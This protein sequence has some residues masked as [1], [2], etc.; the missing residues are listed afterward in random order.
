[1][2]A[3]SW[4]SILLSLAYEVLVCAAVGDPILS[5]NALLADF[6]GSGRAA[7]L[8]RVVADAIFGIIGAV[9]ATVVY[10]ELRLT[11]EGIAPET[12]AAVFE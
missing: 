5:G 3:F 7:V 4:Y 6:E 9:A 2:P 12:V 11:K 8:C 1:L 10:F